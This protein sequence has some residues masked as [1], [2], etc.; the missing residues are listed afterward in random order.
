[1]N[2]CA[3][4]ESCNIMGGMKLR[5]AFAVALAVA[6]ALLAARLPLVAEE[7]F[8]FFGKIHAAADDGATFE[9]KDKRGTFKIEPKAGTVRAHKLAKAKE[10]DFSKKAFI[11]ARH[12]A[13]QRDPNSGQTMPATY[14]Q[15]GAIVLSDVFKP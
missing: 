7:G 5:R 2:C 3:N 14:V 8:R 1:M 9:V 13:S 15:I 11:L 4:R 12:Q 10:A 6:A